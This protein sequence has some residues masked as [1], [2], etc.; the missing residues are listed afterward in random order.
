MSQA[1]AM[2][3]PATPDDAD[4]IVDLVNAE[5][6]SL[7]GEERITR[8][9]LVHEWRE[10]GYELERDCRVA[11]LPDGRLASMVELNTG[12]APFVR[13]YSFFALHP[14]HRHRVDTDALLAWLIARTR[15]ELPRAPEDARVT[16][17]G[18]AL[19]NNDYMIDALERAGFSETRRFYQMR[20]ELDARPEPPRI[21][22]GYEIRPMQP[23][24]EWDTFVANRTAFRDHYG[25][26]DAEPDQD[27]FAEWKHH[28]VDPEDVDPELLLVAATAK[29]EIAGVSLCTPHHGADESMGWVR[30]LGVTPEHRGRGLGKA[31]L[32]ASFAAFHAKGKERAG[33]GVDAQSLT[34]ATKLY[35]A[36]GMHRHR[37]AIQMGYVL[38]DGVELARIV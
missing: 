5:M 8:S 1:D 35:E 19:A 32:R 24:E 29:G 36:C 12:R 11:A 25:S 37:E 20:I 16:L 17:L 31:L 34:G 21:P 38:R 7:T 27:G 22:E 26:V 18:G 2:I 28:L 4:A 33:L 10:P 9:Q 13:H 15:E 23:G 6:R 3:R 30:V 14:E